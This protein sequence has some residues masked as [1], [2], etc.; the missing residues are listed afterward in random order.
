MSNLFEWD[1]E[2]WP[3]ERTC[4]GKWQVFHVISLSSAQP[5]S[6]HYPW[7]S[8][9]EGHI[10]FNTTPLGKMCW[11]SWTMP[12][13][14]DPRLLWAGALSTGTSKP[15]PPATY[16]T[17]CIALKDRRENFTCECRTVFGIPVLCWQWGQ[18]WLCGFGYHK[19]K[20]QRMIG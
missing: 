13:F 20:S 16:S 7:Y 18:K 15:Y 6:F 4:L 19:K 3:S 1:C 8:H 12:V 9:T 17:P 10:F 5:L 14:T 2:E 11:A